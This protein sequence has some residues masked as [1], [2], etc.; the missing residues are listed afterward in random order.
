MA[1]LEHRG[2]IGGRPRDL[3]GTTPATTRKHEMS[4]SIRKNK[5]ANRENSW[6][7]RQ[8]RKARA[9][10]SW[11]RLGHSN[12]RLA[13]GSVSDIDVTEPRHLVVIS[14]DISIDPAQNLTT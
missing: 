14:A 3:T 4:V 11:W 8:V 9:P 12:P 5:M 6:S 10:R 13:A 1:G 2:V 7:A